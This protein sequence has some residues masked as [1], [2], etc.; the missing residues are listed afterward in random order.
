MIAILSLLLLIQPT[1]SA[2]PQ[3]KT[4][5]PHYAPLS[6][7]ASDSL[8]STIKNNYDT[9]QSLIDH[10][11]ITLKQKNTKLQRKVNHL[12]QTVQR[13]TFLIFIDT[14]ANFVNYSDTSELIITPR[15]KGNWLKNIFKKH[16]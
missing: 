11:V 6:G 12:Q 2:I 15:K 5:S 3:G 10:K 7:S 8:I 1:P 14:C 9:I 4:Q 13:D 16:N